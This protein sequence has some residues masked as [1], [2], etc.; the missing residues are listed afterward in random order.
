MRTKTARLLSVAT[1]GGLVLAGLTTAGITNTG[2]A[3][4]PAALTANTTSSPPVNLDNCPT[5]A[6][7]DVNGCV[8][9]LQTELNADDG[10]NLPVDGTFGPATKCHPPR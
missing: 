9:Q 3:P 2:H 1:A 5:L 4:A 8:N 7:G 10:D 6:E